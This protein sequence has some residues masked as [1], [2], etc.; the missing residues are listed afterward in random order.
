MKEACPLL[1]LHWNCGVITSIDDPDIIWVLL[2]TI[3]HKSLELG[4]R[5][6][7]PCQN[8]I[9]VLPKKALSSNVFWL[10]ITNYKGHNTTVRKDIDMASHSR[11]ILDMLELVKHNPSIV[12]IST[13]LHLFRS[14]H[15]KSIP[16]L[17]HLEDI[18]LISI[19]TLA[20]KH[21]FLNKSSIAAT[22]EHGNAIH[23]LKS[24]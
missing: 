19:Q 4:I 20:M 18:N 17:W 11:L 24:S 8:S 5:N 6:T 9:E 14:I 21:V 1:I 3:C 16:H 13:T 7:M 12:K 15:T 22:F 2:S 23:Y 10:H